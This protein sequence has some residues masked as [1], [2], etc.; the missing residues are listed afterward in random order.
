M[1]AGPATLLKYDMAPSA[2]ASW[3]L[4][5]SRTVAQTAVTAAKLSQAL[6][7][8]SFA[9]DT[10][11]FMDVS[12][13]GAIRI[14]VWGVASANDAPVLDLYGWSDSGPGMHV[15][16]VTI[17]YGNFTSAAT[18]GFHA[19]PEAHISIR[20]AFVAGTAYRGTDTYAATNDYEAAITA[21][22]EEADFPASFDVSFLNNQYQ[23]FGAA[24]TTLAG[25]NLG[26]I[27]KALSVKKG[28][29]NPQFTN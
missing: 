3:Q 23:W 17:T 14:Q 4:L 16:K 10:F 24:V 6:R 26:A 28:Y 25:T 5:K 1:A 19:V 11:E 8:V 7:D 21:Y 18:T 27:F 2:V 29:V 12:S 15:G 22:T 9:Q 13:L 20:D